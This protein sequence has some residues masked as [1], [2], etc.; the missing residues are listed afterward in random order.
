[1]FFVV[2]HIAKLLAF[3]IRSKPAKEILRQLHADRFA[4]AN[5]KMTI[6]PEIVSTIHPPLINFSFVD[7]SSLEYIIEM[8]DQHCQEI[9]DEVWD[10]ITDIEFQFDI[11]GKE[12]DSI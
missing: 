2:F 3:D 11:D 9:L 6:S 10:H 7:G 12:V 8:P 5:P 1:V 4:K